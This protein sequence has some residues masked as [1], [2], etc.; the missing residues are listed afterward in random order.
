MMLG[1]NVASKTGSNFMIC[2]V[3]STWETVHRFHD[4]FHPLYSRF[5]EEPEE[6][7]KIKD[8]LF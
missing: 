4:E 8:A 5:V 3:S 2:L 1:M 7:P 6:N